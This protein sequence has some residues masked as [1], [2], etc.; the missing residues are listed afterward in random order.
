MRSSAI[1]RKQR[2]RKLD[3]G[4]QSLRTRAWSAAFSQLSAADRESPLGPE[5][6]GELAKIGYLIGKQSEGADFLSR[7]H[8]GFLARGDA[9]RA[10]RCAFWL[11]FTLLINGEQA[12]AGGWLSRAARLLEG[13]SDCVEQGYLLL[14]EGYQSVHG[15]DPAGARV[16]FVQ[17]AAIGERFGDKDLTT[18]AL[19]G[20]GRALIRQGEIAR[21]ITLLDEAMV[22][23][24]ANEVSPLVAGGVYCS[25]IEACGEIFDL[26]R[27]QEWTSALAQW[28]SSQ[29]DVAPYRGHCLVRRAEILQLHGAWADA[30]G[31]AQ[32]ACECL[33][34]PAPKPA[35]GAAFYRLAELHRLRGEFDE[36]EEA[37]RQ[38]SRWQQTQQPGWA[39]LRLA[40]GN[41]EAASAAIRRVA[42][43][44]REPGSR[45]RILDVYVEIVLAAND[46]GSARAAADELAEIAEQRSVPFLRALSLRAT[47]AVRLAEGDAQ[48]AL[49]VL[50]QSWMIWC[51]LEA[52]YEAARV[53][54]LIALACRE[55]GDNDAAELELSAARETFK[56]L[57]AVPALARL[58]ALSP[59]K[60]ESTNGLLTAR[61]LEVLKLV[62]SGKTNRGIAGKLGISEKT[63]ARHLSNIFNKLDLSSRA[64]ATGYAF[65]N[66]LA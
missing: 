40:Q 14:P 24:T 54:M 5:D 25:V 13:Q 61:E 27:A 1:V 16:A 44:V 3:Q 8:Q 57:H 30:L 15:G 42:E 47:G 31:E 26:R 23:V 62:A 17:A 7:A 34:Q 49:S 36:A 48:S 37:Y 19:Q 11:G 43:E 28:C 6:L 12:Q 60:A 20:Q 38:A 2:G 64:A 10:A 65:R 35:V 9:Q 66:H 22:A 63:V 53:R 29:P 39:Q 46:V 45:A 55:M 4:R 18:L 41:I 21:G 51:D 32:R 52:P 59:K 50:R 56:Q 33:S 58:D